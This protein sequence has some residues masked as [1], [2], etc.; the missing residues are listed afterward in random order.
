[1]PALVGHPNA[2]LKLSKTWWEAATVKG[3]LFNGWTPDVD[4]DLTYSQISAYEVSMTGYTAGGVTL[5]NK[6]VELG[7]GGLAHY[8]ADHAV[9]AA[10]GS[11]TVSRFALL[12]D[13]GVNNWIVGHVDVSARQPDGGPYQVQASTEGWVVDSWEV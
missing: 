13:D 9:W 8:R 6:L 3:A 11:G 7:S 2:L 1:M 4:A 5:A 12:A 10:I